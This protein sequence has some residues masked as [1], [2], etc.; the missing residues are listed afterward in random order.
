MAQR[1]ARW[2]P[3]HLRVWEVKKETGL[4]VAKAKLMVML[5]LIVMMTVMVMLM[6]M[7]V[8]CKHANA[9]YATAAHGVL[10]QELHGSGSIAVVGS[11][12]LIPLQS[13]A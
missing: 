4:E 12:R 2:P 8:G 3:R 6:L 7:V 5:M 9:A 10:L 13:V 1:A 11:E